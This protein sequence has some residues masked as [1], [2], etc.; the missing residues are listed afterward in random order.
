MSIVAASLEDMV[1]TWYDAEP[2]SKDN[3]DDADKLLAAIPK[4]EMYMIVVNSV[5]DAA[6][7]YGIKTSTGDFIFSSQDFEEFID[8]IV[9]QAIDRYE[10]GQDVQTVLDLEE[11]GEMLNEAMI[12]ET[13]KCLAESVLEYKTGPTAT[14]SKTEGQCLV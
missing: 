9:G 1:D 13:F 5:E 14:K 8:Y 10:E 6:Y 4:V 7:V 3:P 12:A 2:V 11:S